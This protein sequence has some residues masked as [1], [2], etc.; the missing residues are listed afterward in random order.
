MFCIPKKEE[1]LSRLSY[2]SKNVR[3]SFE[4]MHGQFYC[5]ARIDYTDAGL[6]QGEFEVIMN[7][8][9]QSLK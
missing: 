4:P 5:N 9:L 8:G 2:R 7:A 3:I 1:S 6:R